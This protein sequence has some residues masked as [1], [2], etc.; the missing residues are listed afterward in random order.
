MARLDWPGA[1]L[2]TLGSPG[3]VG[4]PRCLGPPGTVRSMPGIP[5]SRVQ[6]TVTGRRKGPTW[7]EGLCSVV[8]NALPKL[9]STCKRCK[10]DMLR[11]TWTRNPM[12]PFCNSNCLRSSSNTHLTAYYVS[13]LMNREREIQREVVH[14]NSNALV[15]AS[16]WLD[17][18]G[19]NFPQGSCLPASACLCL[20][21]LRT[22]VIIP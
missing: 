6:L 20:G 14:L 17:R 12:K 2:P 22:V 19:G 10:E 16:Q 18:E 9:L 7:G 5:Q 13:V 3:V 4:R 1:D 8:Y 21:S 15:V 11:C